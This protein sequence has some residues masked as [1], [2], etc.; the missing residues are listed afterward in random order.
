MNLNFTERDCFS[1]LLLR[2]LKLFDR[3]LNMSWPKANPFA[4]ESLGSILSSVEGCFGAS[5]SPT[6]RRTSAP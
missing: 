1:A 2:M 3:G 6:A 4:K 5:G